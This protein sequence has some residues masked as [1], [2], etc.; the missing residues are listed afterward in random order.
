MD[1][2][3]DPSIFASLGINPEANSMDNPKPP[4]DG[5][6]SVNLKLAPIEL[7]KK[8]DGKD[9]PNVKL[10]NGKSYLGKAIVPQGD[11][12]SLKLDD[13]GRVNYTLYL[14]AEIRN[15]AGKKIRTVDLYVTSNVFNQTNMLMDLAK[16]IIG[17]YGGTALDLVG[18]IGKHN[19]PGTSPN[20]VWLGIAEAIEELIAGNPS[21]LPV[22][23]YVSNNLEQATGE[24]GANGYDK[25]K[26]LAYGSDSIIKKF[27]EHWTGDKQPDGFRLITFVKGFKA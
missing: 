5:T 25:M 11:A 14:E 22:E 12:T 21:G 9:V 4:T 7:T 19:T 18:A 10:V 1:I 16:I 27:P 17:M 13:Q 20:H 2:T 8:V 23:G 24:K 3:F 6:Y 26:V 15:A